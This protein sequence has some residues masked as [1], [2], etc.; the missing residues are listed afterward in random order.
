MLS[1]ALDTFTTIHGGALNDIIDIINTTSSPQKAELIQRLLV[2]SLAAFWEVFHEALCRE[3]L[4][5]HPN[6]PSDAE[7]VIEN[8]HN[9]IP[10]KIKRLYSDVLGI[11]DIT[12]SWWGNLELKTGETPDVFRAIIEHLMDVRHDTAHGKWLLPVSPKDCQ[13]FIS[14]TLHLAVRTDEK[15]CELFPKQ[16]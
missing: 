7:K 8:F 4:V 13:D 12:E 5:L 6:P 16:T 11:D 10:R 15:A 2:V 3:T 9:P 1:R 14:A